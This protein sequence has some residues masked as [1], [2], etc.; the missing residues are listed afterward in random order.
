MLLLLL[1]FLVLSAVATV[2]LE[3]ILS[4]IIAFSVFGV[5]LSIIFVVFQAP[6]VALAQAVI[7]SGL[8]TAMFVVTLSK[9]RERKL[10]TDGDA[11]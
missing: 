3:D 10:D 2:A 4:S 7:G 9:V 1:G 8:I 5:L 6:D 11:P